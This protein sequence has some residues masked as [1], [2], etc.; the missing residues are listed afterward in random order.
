MVCLERLTLWS[1][2]GEKLRRRRT[3]LRVIRL[4]A[5]AS[6]GE[7]AI[8]ILDQVGVLS[9]EECLPLESIVAIEVARFAMAGYGTW[10]LLVR[11]SRERGRAVVVKLLNLWGMLESC[12]CA[13]T[14]HD[15]GSSPQVLRKTALVIIRA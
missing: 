6:R 11:C 5:D 13:W 4:V 10:T 2:P 8:A 3:L 1:H 9:T 15:G 14:V 7:F 12:S